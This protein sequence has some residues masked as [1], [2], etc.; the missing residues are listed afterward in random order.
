MVYQ[1]Q[2][3]QTCALTK[4]VGVGHQRCTALTPKVALSSNS[5]GLDLILVPA[6]AFD[7]SFNRLGHGKGFYDRYIK[8][9][10][11]HAEGFALY[12]PTLGGWA[13]YKRLAAAD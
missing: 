6:V 5:P 9:A 8:A 13:L 12:P 3:W 1:N 7:A 2:K 11:V 4:T 10:T